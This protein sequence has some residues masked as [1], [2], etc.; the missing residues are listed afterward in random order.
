MAFP[1]LEISKSNSPIAIIKT[2][3]RQLEIVKISKIYSKYFVTRT[4]GVFELDD[5]YEYKFK[6]T[7]IYFYNFSNSKPLSLSGLSQVDNYLRKIGDTELVN[8]QKIIEI[9]EKTTNQTPDLKDV[10]PD[11][12]DSLDANTQR[13]VQDYF[14][15]DEFSKTNI[16]I[17]VHN[18]KKPIKKYSQ[19]LMGIGMSKDPV[20]IIQTSHKQIDIVKMNVNQKRAYTK[21]GTFALSRDNIYFYK[22]QMVCVFTL[23]LDDSEPALPLQKSHQQSISKMVKG[24]QWFS[25]EVFNRNSKSTSLGQEN[26]ST[27]ISLSSEKPLIQYCADS[28]AIYYS[29]IKEI[30]N[31]KE[32]VAQK[33][34]DPFKKAIPIVVIFACLAGFALL[35]S[36]IPIMIDTVA[37]YQGYTPRY[38]VVTPEQAQNMGIKVGDII[39]DPVNTDAPPTLQQSDNVETQQSDNVETQQMVVEPTTEVV[40]PSDTTPPYFEFPTDLVLQADNPNGMKITYD[41]TAFDDVDGTLIPDCTPSLGTIVQIGTI[42]VLCTVSD[43]SGNESSGTFD[44]TILGTDKSSIVPPLPTVLPPLP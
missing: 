3:D 4:G 14:N 31:A 43:F 23:N 27:N 13:F 1:F 20:A 37:K 42:T 44:V 33:L 40:I 30:W 15:D 19:S 34:S 21:Y 6:K 9:F 32:Q 35:M 39:T 7:G 11:V 36:N 17:D 25:L 16:L 10:Q 5:Q 28:P 29:Q 8:K 2:G 18:N 12:M 22:K 38:L 24:K 26:P 41:V